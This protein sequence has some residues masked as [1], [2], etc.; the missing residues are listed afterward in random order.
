MYTKKVM[1]I[2]GVSS[3]DLNVNIVYIE[4]TVA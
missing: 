1:Y 4:T 3:F 2:I